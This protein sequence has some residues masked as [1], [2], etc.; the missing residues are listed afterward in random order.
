MNTPEERLYDLSLIEEMAMGDESFMKEIAETF[1]SSVPP[2]VES[3][4]GFCKNQ[5]WQKMG[6]EAHHL[7]SNIDT[8]QIASIREDI[9]TIE[10]NGKHG[11][12]LDITPQIVDKVKG[13]L[14]E[15]IEQIKQQ[16]GL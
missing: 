15:V 5:E 6:G 12:D 8:L 4:V 11:L 1:V 13:V 14:D 9:R 16:Y 2:V 7:K 3:M 10:V